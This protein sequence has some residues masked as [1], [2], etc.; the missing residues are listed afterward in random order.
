MN[1]FAINWIK[2]AD[3]AE[4]TVPSGTA[5]K[6]K[7]LKYAEERPEEVNHVIVNKDGSMVCHV[8][9]SFIKVSPPRKVSD[10]QREAARERFAKMWAEK[11]ESGS[12]EELP[13]DLM[14]EFL[15]EEI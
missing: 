13:E 9:V 14:E 11:Q 5:Q 12:A 2:G 15:E 1:E 10:E 3:Y 6:S 4:V 7:L 8:P